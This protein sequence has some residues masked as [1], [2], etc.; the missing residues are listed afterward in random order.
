MPHIYEQIKSD[1][2]EP[3]KISKLIETID[4]LIDEL[5]TIRALAIRVASCG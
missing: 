4:E 3:D 2:L 5:Y 1:S